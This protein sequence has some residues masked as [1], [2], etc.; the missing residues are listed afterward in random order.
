M[1]S[2]ELVKKT[3]NF[4]NKERIPRQLW[5]SS[6]IRRKLSEKIEKIQKIFPDDIIQAPCFYR[7]HLKNVGREYI[8]EIFVDEWGCVFNNQNLGVVG[9]V[10]NPII[11]NLEKLVELRLPLERLSLNISK[12]NDF[13]KKEDKFVLAGAVQRPFERLQFLR[14]S[15]NV[16][17]DL[18]LYK[19]NLSKLITIIH[20]F[21]IKE[22]ELWVKTDIDGIF[23]MDDWGSNIDLLINPELWKEIFKPLYFEYVKIA[24]SKGKYIFMH[25]DG[26]ILKILPDLIDI[27][28]DAINLQFSINGIENLSKYKGQITFWGEIDRYLLEKGS[29]RDIINN[30]NDQKKLLF[31]NGGLIAQCEMSAD[32]KIDNILKYFESFYF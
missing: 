5:A 10:N 14:G 31:H 32:S 3:L 24:H 18:L 26:N 30:T 2:R 19:D 4:D 17:M 6:F 12:V 16:F 25:S 9:E 21:Y 28:I 1:N 20:E 27:G 7:K 8:D 11:N 29:E 13:C 23:L 15:E 22:I